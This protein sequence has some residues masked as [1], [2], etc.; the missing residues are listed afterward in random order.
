M[1]RKFRSVSFGAGILGIIKT[2]IADK[3]NKAVHNNSKNVQK[4]H[5]FTHVFENM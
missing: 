3:P 4:K 5:V 2:I 1:L